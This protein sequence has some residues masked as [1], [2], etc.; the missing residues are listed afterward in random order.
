MKPVQPLF[1]LIHVFYR[2]DA[3]TRLKE[4]TAYFS[5]SFTFFLTDS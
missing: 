4:N 2:A 3:E 1:Y 5:S